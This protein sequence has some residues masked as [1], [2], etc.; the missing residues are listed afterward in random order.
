MN[1]EMIGVDHDIESQ[2]TLTFGP[3]GQESRNQMLLP[4]TTLPSMTNKDARY[5]MVR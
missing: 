1:Y 4:T 3:V 2:E 5:R